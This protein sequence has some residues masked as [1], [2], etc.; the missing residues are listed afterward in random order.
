MRRAVGGACIG[1]ARQGQHQIAH[2]YSQQK[3]LHVPGHEAAVKSCLLHTRGNVAGT[4]LRNSQQGQNVFTHTHSQLQLLRVPGTCTRKVLQCLSSS[5]H[6][7][8]HTYFVTTACPVK[9][10]LVE[11]H[12]TCCSNKCCKKDAF[13]RLGSVRP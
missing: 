13:Y 1:G 3:P 12:A 2:I 4:F 11:L 10:H 7:I 6:T 5:C 9:V 8:S